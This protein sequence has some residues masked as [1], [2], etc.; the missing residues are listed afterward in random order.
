MHPNTVLAHFVAQSDF[1][2]KAT[3]AAQFVAHGMVFKINI[4]DVD[5]L[6]ERC[7]AHCFRSL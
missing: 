2:A 1:I 4:D 7:I 3:N 5:L 6:M